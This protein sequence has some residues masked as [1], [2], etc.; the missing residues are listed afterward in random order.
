MLTMHYAYVSIRRVILFKTETTDKS[1]Q[2]EPPKFFMPRESSIPSQGFYSIISL[3]QLNHNGQHA[4]WVWT[5]EEDRWKLKTSGV[6]DLG[7]N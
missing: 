4:G 5:M 3:F 2:L 1:N 7:D 6:K